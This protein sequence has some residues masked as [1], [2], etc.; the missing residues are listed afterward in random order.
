MYDVRLGYRVLE[1]IDDEVH[2][3]ITVGHDTQSDGFKFTRYYAAYIVPTATVLD[4]FELSVP[5]GYAI[6]GVKQCATG[7]PEHRASISSVAFDLSLELTVR[8]SSAALPDLRLTAGGVV[9]VQRNDAQIYGFH[10]ACVT[11][12][13]RVPIPELEAYGSWHNADKDTSVNS[14]AT[15]SAAVKSQ[16]RK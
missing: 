7:Q 12:S 9:F 3:G 15:I 10:V 16:S 14:R 8:Q 1:N 13:D 5:I 4:T 6:P 11:T 2:Y